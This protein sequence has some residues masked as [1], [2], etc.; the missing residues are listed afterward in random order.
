MP[1]HHKAETYLDAY[2]ETAGV[3]GEKK[4]LLFRALKK[5]VGYPQTPR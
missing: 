3:V 1:L 4:Q 2:I 5:S